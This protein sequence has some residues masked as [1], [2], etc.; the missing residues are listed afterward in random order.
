MISGIALLGA[1]PPQLLPARELM[2]FTLASHILL[3]PFGAA[4]PFLTPLMR[5]RGLRFIGPALVLLYRLDT[6]GDLEPLTDTDLRG[7][8]R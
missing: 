6:R 7:R 4:L 1:A 5:Y 3:V 8:A 2:A